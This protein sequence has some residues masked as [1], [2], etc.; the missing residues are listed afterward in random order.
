MLLVCVATVGSGNLAQCRQIAVGMRGGASIPEPGRV[1][2]S[3]CGS[4][5]LAKS[6][7]GM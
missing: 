7:S 1:G 3:A 4:L 2:P 6:E 5:T